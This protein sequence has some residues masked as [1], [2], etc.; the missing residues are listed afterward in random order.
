MQEEVDEVE[1]E[2]NRLADLLTRGVGV[3]DRLVSAPR[4]GAVRKELRSLTR[5]QIITASTIHHACGITAAAE[6]LGALLTPPRRWFYLGQKH[7]VVGSGEFIVVDSEQLSYTMHLPANTWLSL[8]VDIQAEV[9]G[10]DLSKHTVM[11][12]D[13]IDLPAKLNGRNVGYVW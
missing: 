10:M 2:R 7:T 9:S 8:P 5:L 12:S 6:H 4:F 11:W 3:K 13:D 1:V